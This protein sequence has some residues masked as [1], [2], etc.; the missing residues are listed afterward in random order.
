[1]RQIPERRLARPGRQPSDFDGDTDDAEYRETRKRGRPPTSRGAYN[2][3]PARQLGRVSDEDWA[4]LR[5]AAA[6]RGETFTAWAVRTLL[7]AA[8]REQK[9]RS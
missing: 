3:I 5:A 9:R 6:I 4:T 2:P 1:M 7:A 8:K